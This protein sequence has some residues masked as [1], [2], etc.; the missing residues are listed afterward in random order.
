M[1]RNMWPYINPDKYNECAKKMYNN[2]AK[3]SIV[4]IGSFDIE[5]EPF[6]ENSDSFKDSLIKSGF[7]PIDVAQRNYYGDLIKPAIIYEK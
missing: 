3:G 6:I 5:G 4:V 1:C 2:L 7:K